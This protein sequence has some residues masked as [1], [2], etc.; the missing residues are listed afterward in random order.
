MESDA[1][2]ILGGNIRI[3]KHSN[4]SLMSVLFKEVRKC[5]FN[6]ETPENQIKTNA[7]NYAALIFAPRD[8]ATLIPHRDKSS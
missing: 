6:N 8:A 3:I 5:H 7:D 1:N 2:K 4:F